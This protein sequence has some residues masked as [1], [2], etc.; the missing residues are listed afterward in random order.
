[1]TKKMD[2]NFFGDLHITFEHALAIRNQRAN[3]IGESDPIKISQMP[4]PT[5]Q[6]GRRLVYKNERFNP[7][8]R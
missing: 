2:K 7:A 1:M 5:H 6:N 8:T 3:Y 4:M